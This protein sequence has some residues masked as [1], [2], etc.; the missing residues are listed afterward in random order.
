MRAGAAAA[1]AAA[2]SGRVAVVARGRG[3]GAAG[4]TAALGCGRATSRAT[5]HVIKQDQKKSR[6]REGVG[7]KENSL[8]HFKTTM[9][10][11][12]RGPFRKNETQ[13]LTKVRFDSASQRCF[14]GSLATRHSPHTT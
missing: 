10:S 4:G 3:G 11:M 6:T 14:E 7:Y 8:R 12:L 9:K 2:A 5:A 13:T 1:A